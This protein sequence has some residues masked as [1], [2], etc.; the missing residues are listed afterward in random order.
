MPQTTC[1][2]FNQAL[3]ELGATVCIP[4]GEPQFFVCPV[5]TYCKAFQDGLTTELPI[6]SKKETKTYRK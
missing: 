5:Q 3:M 4:N 1:G 2:D 6:K